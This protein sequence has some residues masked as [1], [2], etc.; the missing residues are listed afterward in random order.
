MLQDQLADL[1]QPT[2]RVLISCDDPE[3]AVSILDGLVEHR[4]G[5]ELVVRSSDPAALNARLVAADV[6]VRAL[7]E[8]RRGLEA[9]VAVFL[10]ALAVCLWLAGLKRT[11]STPPRS[12]PATR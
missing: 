7:V 10:G 11:T 8:Q 5:A 9:G 1:Q 4:D 3:R 2:G 12:P 6:P